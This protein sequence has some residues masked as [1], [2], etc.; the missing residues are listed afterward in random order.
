MRSARTINLPAGLGL[1]SAN[2]F[3]L[4]ADIGLGAASWNSNETF[5]LID[6]L[7]SDGAHFAPNFFQLGDFNSSKLIVMYSEI[8]FH[9]CK[10]CRI[11]CEGVKEA[12][13][14]TINRNNM[15]FGHNT[16]FGSAFGHNMAF[17]LSFGHDAAFGLAFGHN[18]LLITAFGHIK[19]FK[20]C[21]LIVEYWKPIQPDLLW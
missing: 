15:A 9:F 13:I 20:L 21:R 3:N 10:D 19:L 2:S 8:S 4:S 7:S 12:I 6:A 18:K 14:N 11:F 16:A 17:G 1:C 5:K